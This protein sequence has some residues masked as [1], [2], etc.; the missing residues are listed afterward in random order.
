ME[1]LKYAGY[2]GS[3]ELDVARGIC[4]GKILLI[5]DLVTYQSDSI[6]GLQKAFEEAVK[7][8]IQP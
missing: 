4:R 6:K 1:I 2:E 3:A 7:D 8:Y 5:T